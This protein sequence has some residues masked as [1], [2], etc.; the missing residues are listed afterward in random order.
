MGVWIERYKPTDAE[1]DLFS[2]WVASTEVFGP[3]AEAQSA[4]GDLYV[5]TIRPDGPR[6]EFLAVAHDQQVF[7]KRI[8][9]VGAG[10]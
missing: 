10:P 5:Y 4:G 1:I 8:L 6:L 3:P 9:P 2:F 7:M